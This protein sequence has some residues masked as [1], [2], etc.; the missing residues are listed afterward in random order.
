MGIPL[1]ETDV[2]N[3]AEC[4][5]CMKCVTACPRGNTT[6]AIAN[7]DVRP[8]LISVVSDAVILGSYYSADLAV[9][10]AGNNLTTISQTTDQLAAVNKLYNDGTYEGTGTGFR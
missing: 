7:N 8:L 1:Y 10:A 5:N 2:V 3:S 4:I 6:Y 9:N